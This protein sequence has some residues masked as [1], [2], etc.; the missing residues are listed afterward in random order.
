MIGPDE[1]LTGYDRLKLPE[2]V[3]PL[4]VDPVD[5]LAF[6]PLADDPLADDPLANPPKT[7]ADTNEPLWLFGMQFPLT[8]ADPYQQLVQAPVLEVPLQDG[9][10]RVQRV[11]LL[12]LA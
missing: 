3:N 5:P 10:L 6:D 8:N 7:A 11:P 4:A 2:L 12:M 9:G 1:E